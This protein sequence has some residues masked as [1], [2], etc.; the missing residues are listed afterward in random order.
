MKHK[1]ADWQNSPYINVPAFV[2]CFFCCFPLKWMKRFTSIYIS[3]LVIILILGN[4]MLLFIY[5]IIIKSNTSC[6]YFECNHWGT[7]W[8]HKLITFRILYLLLLNQ[9][10]FLQ[11]YKHI[12]VYNNARIKNTVKTGLN[13]EMCSS[14]PS[15]L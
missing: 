12:L 10:I 4:Y 13:S 1:N 8:W 6:R 14:M 11:E 3:S 5:V 2:C 7:H 15:F 9:W